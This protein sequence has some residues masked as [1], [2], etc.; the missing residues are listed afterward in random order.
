MPFAASRGVRIYWEEEGRGDPLLL[1]MGLGCS[2]RMWHSLRPALAEHFRLILFDNRGAGASGFPLRP[3]RISS[4]ARDAAAVLDA[5]GVE[6]AH[7]FGVSMGGMIAQEFALRFPRRVR[8]LVLGCTSSGGFPTGADWRAMW[9]LVP[10]F[11][12]PRDEQ[13]RAMLPFLFHPGT[14][15]ERI[16]ADVAVLRANYPRRPAFLAQL[17][18]ILAWRSH[19]RLPRIQA[20][21]LV[22]HGVDDRLVPVE[23][24]RI[25]ARRIPN[26]KLVVIPDANHIFPTDQPEATLKAILEFLP[27]QSSFA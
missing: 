21:T 18:G 8:K 10:G 19:S 2:L 1:I 25:V 22:L 24:G 6:R 12:A 5:A 13:L 23:N 15:R 4:M 16:E 20:E 17:A 3:C 14:P 26:S 7:V 27:D 11:T 9:A